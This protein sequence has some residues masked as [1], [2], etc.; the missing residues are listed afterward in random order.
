M[1]KKKRK[2]NCKRTERVG[3]NMQKIQEEVEEDK[4]CREQGKAKGG[5]K[6][7]N[8]GEEKKKENYRKH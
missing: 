1:L 5:S 8:D 6:P 7:N 2:E 3:K 4:R